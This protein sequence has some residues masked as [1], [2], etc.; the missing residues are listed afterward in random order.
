MNMD[1]VTKQQSDYIW[2]DREL[3]FDSKPHLL[4]CRRG[5]QMIDSINSVED[6]KGNNGERGS[7]IVTN[8]RLIWVSHAKSSINLSVGLS[9]VMSANIK[10]AK[11]K[12]RGATQA[13]VVLAKFST[14]FEFIFTS[15]V[16]NSPRL[17]TTVQSVLRAYETSKLYRDL[18]LRG[19][20]VKDGELILLPQEQIFAKISGVWNLSSEQGNLGSFFLTNVRV[21]WHANLAT[22]FNVSLPYMQIKSI[23]VRESKFG[24]ALVLETFQK[25]GG[26]ILGFRVDPQEKIAEVFQE[27]HSLFQIYSVGPL[28]GVDFTIESEAPNI[29]QLLQPS[30]TED[31]ELLED[32]EDTHAIASYYAA[33]A[34]EDDSRFEAVQFDKRLGLA[35]EGL[36]DGITLDQ[37]W[38]VI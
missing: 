28:F 15:L 3:R 30:V 19:S 37:L 34:V 17:F 1:S 21:V 6:T 13:L 7:L 18:K 10:Q 25:S 32:T 23:R 33:S 35:V 12:L 4:Q 5:E 24:R 36:V 22:N 9:T 38:R 31:T 27:I 11:S 29:E 16:K 2:Q 8:L 20:I 26:Y 14:R